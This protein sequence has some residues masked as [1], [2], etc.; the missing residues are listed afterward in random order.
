MSFFGVS[1]NVDHMLLGSN[2]CGQSITSQLT[3][4]TECLAGVN[5]SE[6]GVTFNQKKLI[7]FDPGI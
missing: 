4:V 7:N 1:L 2:R 3:L 5:L 6:R